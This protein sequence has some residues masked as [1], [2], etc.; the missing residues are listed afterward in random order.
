M[1]HHCPAC[2]RNVLTRREARFEGFRKT[3]EDWVCT[4]CG[5][6]WPVAENRPPERAGTR[7]LE[8]ESGDANDK[9]SI[10]GIFDESDRPVRPRIFDPS[11][12][13]RSCGWC[14]HMV[15]SP[16]SQ[17]CGLKEREVEATDLCDAFVPKQPDQGAEGT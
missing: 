15:V 14:R 6:R 16:F 12:R 5:H 7:I 11:E 17:R 9:P 2:N 10:A 4:R 1:E 13:R 8:F 3:G